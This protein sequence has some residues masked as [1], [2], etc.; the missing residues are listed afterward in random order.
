MRRL[1]C[2]RVLPEVRGALAKMLRKMH[3]LGARNYVVAALCF[4]VP[5]ARSKFGIDLELSMRSYC[6]N[7]LVSALSCSG[8]QG[9]PTDRNVLMQS[10]CFL[11]QQGGWCLPATRPH[12]FPIGFGP[13]RSKVG[14]RQATTNPKTWNQ[15][16]LSEALIQNAAGCRLR[17]PQLDAQQQ[18]VSAKPGDHPT[19]PASFWMKSKIL[20]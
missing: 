15:V 20:L 8:S 1:H 13:Q 6:K 10:N 9:K 5:Q 12:L 11:D 3:R 14:T 7:F 19:L 2:G 16:S 18:V 17:V 4:Q